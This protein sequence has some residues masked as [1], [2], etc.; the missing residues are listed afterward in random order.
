MGN[1]TSALAMAFLASTA[2]MPAGAAVAAAPSAQAA[3]SAPETVIA[4]DLLSRDLAGAPGK[5]VR[6]LTVE[7]LPGGASLPHRHNAQVFVYVLEGRLRMQ[8]AGKP[9]V[10]VGPGDTF[11]EGPDDIHQVSE[12]ASKTAPA[13]FLVLMIKDKREPVSSAAGGK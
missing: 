8:V 11:Y 9:A 3:S 6:M 10:L 4:K 7:Y 1:M 13:K 2:L 12:N 5:E